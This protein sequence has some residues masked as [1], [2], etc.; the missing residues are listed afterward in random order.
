[1]ASIPEPPGLGGGAGRDEGGGYEVEAPIREGWGGTIRAGRYRRSGRRVTVED[2]RPD[3]TATPGLVDRLGEIG[4]AA[5]AV[6]DPHLLAVYDLVDEAGSYRFIA[7]WCDGSSLAALLG[8]GALPPATAVG[9]VSDILAGLVT[10]HA[11]GLFHGHVGPETVVIDAQRCARLAELAVC[12]AAAPPGYTAQTDVR[13]AARLG[14]HLLRDAGAR[15][16]PVRRPLEAAA[17]DGPADPYRLREEVEMAAAAVLGPGWRD[18]DAGASRHRPRRRA[19]LI[20]LGALLVLA[21]AATAA[22]LLLGGSGGRV[23]PSTPLV[24]G[25]DATVVVNPA[26]G[27]CN[28]TFGFVG[29]GS[30]SGTGTLVYRWEQ[31]DGQAT[32]DTSLPITSSEG[33]FELTEAWRLQGSQTVNGAM[34]LHILRPLDR[35][36]SRSFRYSCP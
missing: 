27:G 17:G 10:L 23:S 36:I 7:E 1:V 25:S 12:G 14:L 3:L 4:Q 8:R 21:A 15:F 33:A 16:D 32:S 2:V 22:V 35:R 26:T 29:Q 11:H 31:S 5:A 6:R 28:T 13:D 9:A 18:Q 30:L 34:T 19:I 24:V 20:L